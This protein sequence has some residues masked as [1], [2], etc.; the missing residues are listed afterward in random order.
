MKQ[1]TQH[2]CSSTPQAAPMPEVS[3]MV[4]NRAGGWVFEANDWTRLQRFLILGTEL[5]SYYA[6]ARELTREAATCIDRLLEAGH[7]ARVVSEIVTISEAGRAPKNDP[8]IL[9]LA[10]CLKTAPDVETRRAASEAT[11]R[12]CRTG[13]HLASLMVAI[14]G[15]GG[16]G[17][18]SRKAVAGWIGARAAEDLAYQVVKYGQRQD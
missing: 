10:L 11:P 8:A 13:S 18:L 4:R 3:G 15:L 9:A 17:P 7:G 12:V 5:G 14:E 6:S 2:F 1:Y 16:W